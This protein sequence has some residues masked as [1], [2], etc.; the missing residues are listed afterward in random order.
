MISIIYVHHALKRKNKMLGLKYQNDNQTRILLYILIN[1]VLCVQVAALYW[2][3][4]MKKVHVTVYNTPSKTTMSLYSSQLF[5][6]GPDMIKCGWSLPSYVLVT[7]HKQGIHHL[8]SLSP[9]MMPINICQFAEMFS[10]K[11]K[12]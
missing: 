6:G 4:I 2:H 3:P 7:S 1:V 8:W 5:G 9:N 12:S 11:T 10:R